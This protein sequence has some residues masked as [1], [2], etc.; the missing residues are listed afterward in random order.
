MIASVFVLKDSVLESGYW[1]Q[2]QVEQ[3]F[4]IIVKCIV[5]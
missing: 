1:P 5:S 4:F 2:S 3:F